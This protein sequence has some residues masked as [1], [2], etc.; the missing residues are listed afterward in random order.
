MKITKRFFQILSGLVLAV[1]LLSAPAVADKTTAADYFEAGKTAFES[2]KYEEAVSQITRAI[3]ASPQKPVYYYLKGLSLEKLGEFDK[4]M[5]EF[6]NYI[7]IS[8]ESPNGYAGRGKVCEVDDC[9]RIV[10]SGRNLREF[11]YQVL[12]VGTAS[13]FP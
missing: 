7:E 6:S 10:P 13:A 4:A 9:M 3:E 2:Q 12:I 5:N 8:P 1:S 11:S